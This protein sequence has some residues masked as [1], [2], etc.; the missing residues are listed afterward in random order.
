MVVVEGAAVVVILAVGAPLFLLG[1]Q[2]WAGM[3]TIGVLSLALI[4]QL[5]D[6]DRLRK[7]LEKK[8]PES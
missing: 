8:P 2:F 1:H 7:Q 3:F 4:L 6:K 5:V